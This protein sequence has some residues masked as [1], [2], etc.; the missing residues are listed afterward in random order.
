MLLIGENTYACVDSL[1]SCLI[2]MNKAFPRMKVSEY[3]YK[4]Q[5][6]FVIVQ[7]SLSKI[8][9]TPDDRTHT[10]FFNKDCQLVC[11]WTKG[12]LVPLNRVIPD[13]IEKTKIIKLPRPGKIDP[14]HP[15][16]TVLSDTI[17]RLAKQLNARFVQQYDY[18]GQ[19][20]YFLATITQP[21]YELAQK[22]VSTTEEKYYDSAGKWVA[23][24]RRATAGMFSRS[25]RWEPS[26]F[27]PSKLVLTKSK[28]VKK[29]DNYIFESL[30][31]PG[32]KE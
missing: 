2:Q 32:N 20:V 8:V 27:V 25:Q 11:T 6:W 21:A 24:F 14:Q 7:D 16:D 23:T 3:D 17:R 13:S 28:W 19:A 4:G 12:G 5:S 26:S 29:N 30:F 18:N 10:K 9:Q 22:G 1:P 15:L 31:L